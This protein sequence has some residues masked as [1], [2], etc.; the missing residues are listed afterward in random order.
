MTGWRLAAA[1]FAALI[2]S[3][4]NREPVGGPN[5]GASV[6]DAAGPHSSSLA[7]SAPCQMRLFIAG[8]GD[9]RS[10]KGVDAW[11]DAQALRPR[12]AESA[13]ADPT[14]EFG[15]DEAVLRVDWKHR[16]VAREGDLADI[17]RELADGNRLLDGLREKAV[18]LGAARLVPSARGYFLSELH[19]RNG[20]S[21]IQ[22]V[23]LA[24]ERDVREDGRRTLAGSDCILTVSLGDREESR[25]AVPPKQRGA[26]RLTKFTQ[27][28]AFKVRDVR[29]GILFAG[30]GKAEFRRMEDSARGTANPDPA[31]E[32][33][34]SAGRQIAKRVVDFFTATLTFRIKAPQGMDKGDAKIWVDGK[35][36][37]AAD[38]L[39]VLALEHH[40]S[41]TLDGCRPISRKVAIRDDCAGKVLVARL[42]FK[43]LDD[44]AP[45]DAEDC[46]KIAP[47]GE[48]R[49]PC[50]KYKPQEMCEERPESLPAEGLED[51]ADMDRSD[52]ETTESPPSGDDLDRSPPGSKTVVFAA[53]PGRGVSRP[54]GAPKWL[55]LDP[56]TY[57]AGVDRV[58]FGGIDNL[59]LTKLAQ[60]KYKVLDRDAYDTAAREQGFGA[61]VKLIP[62]GY[63]IRG[64]IVQMVPSGRARTIAGAPRSEWIATV[65]IRVNDLRTQEAY[66]A[67]TLRV[68]QSVET[69]KDMLV[70]VVQRMALAILMR[71][72]PPYVMD[73]DNDDGTL[74][75]SY[76][77]DFL[78][79]GEQYEVRRIKRIVDGDTGE[80]VKRE[81]TVGVCEIT[82]VGAKTSS[83]KLVS[84]K[85]KI[86][87]GLRFYADADAFAPPA[88]GGEIVA[89]PG[90]LPRKAPRIAV[91]PFMSRRSTFSV[92]GRSLE[93][94]KWMDD[95]ADHLNEDL[96]KCGSFR[97]LD[98]TFG[99]EVDRE[100][101]RIVNDPNASPNDVCRLSNKLA[102]DYLVVAEATFSD[103]ASPGTDF[104][105]GLPLPPPS[106]VFAEVRFRC[107]VAPTTEIAWADTIRL[108]ASM[109]GGDANQFSSDSAWAAAEEIRR[110]V[111][112]R[113]DP[114]G[115][116]AFEGRLSAERAETA[117][118]RETSERK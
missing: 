23:D 52:E 70:Y 56:I 110:A 63:S 84:G 118:G 103:V 26:L 61:D 11:L 9:A 6:A 51:I 62:A 105:T 64:E 13:V 67:E 32:L 38:R 7:A 59:L 74:T 85:A 8:F 95:V 97:A 82:D 68:K 4:C 49:L 33:A 96:T 44:D 78:S 18:S 114:Q 73:Y 15:S 55:V 40:V 98:R 99:P 28:Y 87:D 14:P 91:A 36:V 41:A 79:V 75:V 21:L 93:A 37:T 80:E 115:F 65:S 109:F 31:G 1:A 71:D 94:R 48:I 27:P 19:A 102:A 89:R 58:A 106:A 92:L 16:S 104:A 30:S 88:A 3:G 77:R 47:M 69:P 86:K 35:S 90:A 45:D 81:K 17:A 10:M 53:V 5:G 112:R 72:Y 57:Q 22:V 83:A 39:C 46:V 111:Q 101:N 60:S 43:P 2:F 108:D 12:A 20:E 107:V 50:P 42:M 117:R 66:E 34:A 29:G 100:L 116:A 25:L 113:L 24:S 54:A 76:G